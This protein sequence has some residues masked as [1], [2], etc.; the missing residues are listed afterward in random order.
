MQEYFNNKQSYDDNTDWNNCQAYVQANYIGGNGLKFV[1]LLHAPLRS[2][3]ASVYALTRQGNAKILKETICQSVIPA[4]N[5]IVLAMQTTLDS[6]G[7]NGHLSPDGTHAQEGLPC[8]LQTYAILLWLF[9]QLGIN[10]SIYGL[11]FKMTT[12]IYNTINV[13]GPNLGSGVI[14]G[15]DAQNLLAQEVAIMAYKDGVKFIADNIAP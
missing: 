9:D 10:K 15:T 5:A 7:D 8:L 11:Q 4:G 6:L 13:P 14:E 1:E 2:N 3:A 12:A